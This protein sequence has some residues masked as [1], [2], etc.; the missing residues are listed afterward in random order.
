MQTYLDMG[1]KPIYRLND[2]QG[3]L[4]GANKIMLIQKQ[5]PK[6]IKPN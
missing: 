4:Q 2:P 5:P 3:Q 1:D 6:L